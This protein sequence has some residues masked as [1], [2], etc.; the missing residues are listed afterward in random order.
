[1]FF[2]KNMW[3]RFTPAKRKAPFRHVCRKLF[4]ASPS[5]TLP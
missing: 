5:F 4:A 2:P 1:M 3:P